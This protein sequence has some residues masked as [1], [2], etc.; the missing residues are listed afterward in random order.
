MKKLWIY[1]ASNCLPWRLETA[2]QCWTNILAKQ[3]EMELINR[4]REGCDNLYLYHALCQ[5]LA[6]H[7][8]EDTVIVAWTHP[9]RKTWVLDESNPDHVEQ[10]SKGALVYPGDPTFF[11][12]NNSKR[13]SGLTQWANFLPISSGNPFFDT[14]F[15]NYHNDHEQRLNFHAYV[16]SANAK[17]SCKKFFMYFS[18][19]SIHNVITDVELTYLEFVLD[20]G[21]WI[22][23]DDLHCNPQGHVELAEIIWKK[24]SSTA[25]KP[26]NLA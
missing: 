22:D 7:S 25:Q 6:C 5:D 18:R 23:K 17:I 11:R 4:S 12:N 26:N 1:G 20:S 8:P 16:N 10:V 14:W 2:A 13:S 9:N 19:E 24:L 3:S 21:N 15:A